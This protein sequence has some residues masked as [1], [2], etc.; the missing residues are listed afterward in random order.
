M[1]RRK[2]KRRGKMWNRKRKVRMKLMMKRRQE[3]RTKKKMMM[4]MM[5]EEEG[6]RDSR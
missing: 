1:K 5:M 2:V 3:K 4:M 6:G